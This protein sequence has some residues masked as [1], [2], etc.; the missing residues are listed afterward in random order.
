MKTA[1][2]RTLGIA[3]LATLGGCSAAGGGSTPTDPT[4][5][6]PLGGKGDYIAHCD[7]E[8][9]MS[10][11]YGQS[12]FHSVTPF[13]DYLPMRTLESA[14]DTPSAESRDVERSVEESDIF[15]HDEE[16]GLLYVLNSYRGLQVIDVS[17]ADHPR[18][19][20][21]TVLGGSPIEMYREGD[22]A[23]VLLRS[24]E[25]VEQGELA[26]SVLR[27][28]DLSDP[29]SPV[30]IGDDF[31]LEGE[32][33][34][35]RMLP[36]RDGAGQL[37]SNVIYVASQVYRQGERASV[38]APWEP[39][40]FVRSIDVTQPSLPVE[41]DV[42][43]LEG[44]GQALHVTEDAVFVAGTEW[45]T[46]RYATTR[47][48]HV[49]ISD[50]SGAIRVGGEIEVEGTLSWGERGELQLDHFRDHLRVASQRSGRDPATGRWSTSIRM[51]TISTA[52]IDD[53][54]VVDTLDFAPEHRILATRFAGDLAYLFHATNVD[55]LEII[56]LRDPSAI[57]SLGLLEI[58]GFVDRIDVR[59]DKLIALGNVRE[60]RARHLA[61]Y[62]FD[63]EDPTRPR[64]LGS[65]TAGEGWPWT[66]ANHDLKSYRVVDDLGLVLLPV[67][68]SRTGDDGRWSYRQ[69]LQLFSFDLEACDRGDRE[70]C[71]ST[72][73]EIQGHGGVRRAFP[74]DGR[75]VSFSDLELQVSDVTDPDRPRIVGSL[76][77]AADI[78]SFHVVHGW[79]AMVVGTGDWQNRGAELRIVDPAAPDERRPRATLDLDTPAGDVHLVGDDHLLVVAS[80]GYS[81]ETIFTLVDLSRPTSPWVVGQ[82]RTAELGFRRWGARFGGLLPAP[83]PSY[84]VAGDALAMFTWPRE[85]EA[86][87]GK[88]RLYSIFDA[89][90]R[91][92]V[93][94]GE[95]TVVD[96]RAIDS[97]LWVTTYLPVATDEPVLDDTLVAGTSDA[98]DERASAAA[99]LPG[100]SI[101]PWRP[102]QRTV[103][104]LL[105]AIDL[106]DARAPLVGAPVNVPGTFA[107]VTRHGD[108][109][110]IV[111]TSDSFLVDGA[112]VTAF[113][114]MTLD[115]DRVLLDDVFGT[116]AGVD[117]VTVVGDHAFF[118]R[119]SLS[120]GGPIPLGDDEEA[121]DP[122]V[123]QAALV[124]LTI[125]HNAAAS[126]AGGAVTI[127]RAGEAT[128]DAGYHTDLALVQDGL[129]FVRSGYGKVLVF[130]VTQPAWGLELIETA[131]TS[132][133]WWS[134]AM[135]FD[136]SRLFLANGLYGLDAFD[137]GFGFAQQG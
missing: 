109:R 7:P 69:W 2:S 33:V 21:R 131:R 1:P 39:A 126:A 76:E 12:E 130:D 78:Q 8:D 52:D 122:S 56:D 108:G 63:V 111:F 48:R 89:T 37:V 40:S 38:Y 116:P 93:E 91:K 82:R 66:S 121:S 129:A 103:K 112:A 50:L 25:E 45:S 102:R 96:M 115:G 120:W 22:F 57:R 31:R 42:V 29:T 64:E 125:R 30:R 5:R 35:S 80:D 17:D 10:R 114:A 97:T 105:R 23:F 20:G 65:A 94:L 16:R 43:E 3:L 124:A 4:D 118:V 87:G 84:A 85:G 19:V 81:G 83:G 15:R 58:D 59:G 72:R 110:T 134:G 75:V 28:L 77:L 119:N 86:E 60:D 98:S 88:L 46:D 117:R 36:A 106:S 27:V 90:E 92:T 13:W 51:T 54:K 73:G 71:V 62:V 137:L 32:V 107:G 26:G 68:E 11:C 44:R 135:F 34:G 9:P 49:D 104:Y 99:L 70:A 127:E 74:V 55:P 61:L 14:T 24:H 95:E 18:F 100:A 101:A 132:A 123:R 67:G 128:L 53:P 41:V 136:G 6:N 113:D 47:I 79:G 133:T